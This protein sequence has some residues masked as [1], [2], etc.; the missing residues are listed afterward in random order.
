MKKLKRLAQMSVF[1]KNKVIHSHYTYSLL[2]I[3]ITKMMR[4]G[5]LTIIFTFKMLPIMIQM[6]LCR[7]YYGDAVITISFLKMS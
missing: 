3:K 2:N 6:V 5:Q 4:V 1:P 7:R